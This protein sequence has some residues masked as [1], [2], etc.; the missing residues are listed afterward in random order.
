MKNTVA[1]ALA[2]SLTL[3][4]AQAGAEGLLYPRTIGSGESASV[5]YGPGPR[6]NIVGGGIALMDSEGENTSVTYRE[7]V[8]GQE[9][10]RARA[11]GG[12]EDVSVIYVPASATALTVASV[13]AVRQ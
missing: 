10:V 3:G 2:A 11:V 4:S 7:T 12:G 6:G 9:P 5:D 1:L 13:S 8:H